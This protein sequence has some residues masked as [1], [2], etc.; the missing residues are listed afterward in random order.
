MHAAQSAPVDAAIL[1]VN[2]DAFIPC[3][4]ALTQ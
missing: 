3:S 1:A 2:V 4:A